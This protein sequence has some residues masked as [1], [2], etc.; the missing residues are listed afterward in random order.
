M[1]SFLKREKSKKL[2]NRYRMITWRKRFLE[3]A[4]AGILIGT[5][6]LIAGLLKTENFLWRSQK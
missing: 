3:A 2:E 1:L 4:A 5:L 6:I